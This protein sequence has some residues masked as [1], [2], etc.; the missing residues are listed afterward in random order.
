[1]SELHGTGELEALVNAEFEKFEETGDGIYLLQAIQACG[2]YR[3]P[4][5]FNVRYAFSQ[6]LQ[7]YTD[8][9]AKTLGEAF[10]VEREKSWNQTGHLNETKN[11]WKVYRE[12]LRLHEEE[13]FP[14]DMELHQLVGDKFGISAS[15]ARNYWRKVSKAM[16]TSKK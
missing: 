9:K 12:T 7:R 6:A 13:R 3:L 4:I 10:Y 16:G 15:T 11:A 8:G 14:L 1:M 2:L 5:P